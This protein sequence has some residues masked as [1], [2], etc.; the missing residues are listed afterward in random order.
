M[1]TGAIIQKKSNLILLSLF[2]FFLLVIESILLFIFNTSNPG[3]GLALG[4]LLFVGLPIFLP[5]ALAISIIAA[6]IVKIIVDS[7]NFSSS[8]Y[9]RGFSVTASIIASAILLI[10]ILSLLDLF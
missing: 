10:I 7:I 2:I 8:V 5:A 4:V 3:D 9:R 1:G 6:S